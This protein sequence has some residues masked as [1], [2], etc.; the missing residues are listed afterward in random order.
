M[1]AFFLKANWFSCNSV[2]YLSC[3]VSILWKTSSMVSWIAIGLKSLFFLGMNTDL[4]S[5]SFRTCLIESGLLRSSLNMMQSFFTNIGLLLAM[6]FRCLGPIPEGP[7]LLWLRSC[8]IIFIICSSLIL[9]KDFCCF[10]A[11]FLRSAVTLFG[12]GYFF[13]I[14]SSLSSLDKC[15]NFASFLYQSVSFTNAFP[16]ALSWKSA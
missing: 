11:F 15:M 12:F 14:N 6:Y 10:L 5:N 2:C 9:S 16:I 7:G 1:C 8:E 3:S 4:N 13:L